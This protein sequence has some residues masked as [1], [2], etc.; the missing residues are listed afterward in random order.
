ME[1][2]VPDALLP[3][4]GSY[5]NHGDYVRQVS[6][7]ARQAVD[8]LINSQV[9]TAAEGEGLHACVVRSRAGNDAGKR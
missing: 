8:S 4:G 7:R 3:P 9:V 1:Q 5:R 6:L 2:D